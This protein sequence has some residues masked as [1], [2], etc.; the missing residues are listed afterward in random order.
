MEH[1]LQERAALPGTT[2]AAPEGSSSLSSLGEKW[3]KLMQEA[4]ARWVRAEAFLSGVSASSPVCA[5]AAGGAVQL[6][7][8]AL[9]RQQDV[10]SPCLCGVSGSVLALLRGMEME[11]DRGW[12]SR[13]GQGP[14]RPVSLC[15]LVPVSLLPGP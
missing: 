1:V 7:R 3:G 6:P 9:Q 13:A 15:P 4:E 12:C 5:G 8:R 2:A 11:Q 10:L 14:P